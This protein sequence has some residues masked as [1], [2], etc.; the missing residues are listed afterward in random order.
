LRT[1]FVVGFTLYGLV[2]GFLSVWWW[3]I[4][5]NLF[6]LNIPGMILGDAVYGFSI[7]VFGDPFSSQAHFSIPWVLRVPQNYVS[8]SVVFWFFFG[9]IIQRLY[10][11]F[12]S[13]TRLNKTVVEDAVYL[14]VTGPRLCDCVE[15]YIN[16]RH[17]G[18][19]V[20]SK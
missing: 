11:R 14:K 20:N 7:Q 5:D 13:R 19:N 17:S 15:S 6:L 10:V 18:F 16:P 8:V 1:K 9:L 3:G 12:F 2:V 4:S